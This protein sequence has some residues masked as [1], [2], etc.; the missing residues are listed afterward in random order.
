MNDFHEQRRKN[1]EFRKT[2]IGAAFYKFRNTFEGSMKADARLEYTDKGLAK[3]RLLMQE[4]REAERE[5]LAL[6]Q[7][8]LK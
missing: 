8:L 4:A 7:G 6:L 3:A 1:E 2:P 5:F